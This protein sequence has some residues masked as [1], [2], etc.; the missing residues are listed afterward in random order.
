[1]KAAGAEL[2]IVPD[3]ERIILHIEEQPLGSSIVCIL[4]Q[5]QRHNAVALQT[6]KGLLDVTQ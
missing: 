5:F 6:L 4:D 3:N 1:M 2:S